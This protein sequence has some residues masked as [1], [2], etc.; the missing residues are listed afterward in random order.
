MCIGILAPN[1]GGRSPIFMVYIYSSNCC[2]RHHV[3][4][5]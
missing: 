2:Q 3:Q 5:K 1:F 4:R